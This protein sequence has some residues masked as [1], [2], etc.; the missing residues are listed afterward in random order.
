MAKSK[1][2]YIINAISAGLIPNS[3]DLTV[4]DSLNL[5][6]TLFMIITKINEV[7][8]T[9]KVATILPIT[10]LILYPTK[11]AELIATGPG[12]ICEIP[13]ISVNSV[14]LIQSFFSTIFRGGNVAIH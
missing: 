14:L 10:P 12:V 1:K 11:V 6:K 3:A 7:V 8:I 4:L 9:P 2:A 5:S 13:I